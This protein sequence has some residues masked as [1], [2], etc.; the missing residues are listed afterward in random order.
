[1]ATEAEAGRGGRRTEWKEEVMGA[2]EWV[3]RLLRLAGGGGG[4]G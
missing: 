1:M 2:T 3:L 4:G